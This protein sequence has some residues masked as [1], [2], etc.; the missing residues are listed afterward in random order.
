MKGACEECLEIHQ[1][2]FENGVPSNLDVVKEKKG[3]F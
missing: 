3:K 2:V 1:K